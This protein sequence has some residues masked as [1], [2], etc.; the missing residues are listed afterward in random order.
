M[1][2]ILLFALCALSL[3]ACA[4][5]KKV[6]TST[7]LPQ[8]AR[9][10]MTQYVNADD[11]LLITQEGRGPWTE[12]EI[13]LTDQSDWEFDAQGAL[14]KVE[15]L[16]GIPDE[17]IPEPILHQVRT[18]YPKAIITEYSIDT[19]DQ[20]VKLNNGIELTFNLQGKLLRTEVD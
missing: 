6:I 14:T 16:A 20:E 15:I 3:T 1:N 19:R 7:D 9:T 2:R 11:V 17:L 18:S 12:Y 5:D 4:D 10:L 13:R 8:A